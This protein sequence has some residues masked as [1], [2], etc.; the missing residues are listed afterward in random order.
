M[1]KRQI[2]VRLPLLL[3][4]III[5]AA[6]I[7]TTVDTEPEKNL[8]GQTGELENSQSQSER[9]ST[10]YSTHSVIPVAFSP[11]NQIIASGKLDNTIELERFKWQD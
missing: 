2:A 1:G 9:T 4:I 7:S 11:D 3:T 10:Q 8:D 6:I 5:G